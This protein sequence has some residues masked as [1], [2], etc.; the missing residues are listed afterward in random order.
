M[1]LMQSCQ[2]PPAQIEYKVIDIDI[3]DFPIIESSY[4]EETGKVEMTLDE[5]EKLY[6]FKVDLEKCKKI[7]EAKTELYHM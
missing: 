7:Y 2:T 1:P 3:P 6:N 4:N 5:F